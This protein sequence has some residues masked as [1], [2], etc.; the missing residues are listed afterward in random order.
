MIGGLGPSL[1]LDHRAPL[2]SSARTSACP[3]WSAGW[4]RA[5]TRAGPPPGRGMR[6]V[7]STRRRDPKRC[8]RARERS[9]RGREA[10]GPAAPGTARRAAAPGERARH[11][12]RSSRGYGA[13]RADP[14]AGA[15]RPRHD[16][17]GGHRRGS[18]VR[19]A[20]AGA[21]GVLRVRVGSLPGGPALR[22]LG[23]ALAADD[24]RVARARLA[25]LRNPSPARSRRG[26][27]APIRR[28]ARC[29]RR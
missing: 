20:E 19:P 21:V 18:G 17:P 16:P 1:V 23:R 11:Q 9:P 24:L 15:A 8:R 22:S 6:T 2:V 12:Q 14:G 28:R 26:R 27:R 25:R 4:G 13:R 29:A 3:V 10:R 5:T 7:A